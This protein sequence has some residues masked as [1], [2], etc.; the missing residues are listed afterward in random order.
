VRPRCRGARHRTGRADVLRHLPDH[1]VPPGRRRPEGGHRRPARRQALHPR[2]GRRRE[3]QRARGRGAVAHR[4]GTTRHARGGPRHHPGP[5]RR[6]AGDRRRRA[7]PGRPGQALGPAERA[8]RGGRGGLRARIGL[9]LRPAADHLVTTLPDAELVEDWHETR[10]DAGLERGRVFVQIPVSWD[11]SDAE[12]ALDRAHELFRWSGLDWPVNANL[13]D[14]K[15]F[16]AATAAVRREDVAESVP[17][18]PDL[19]A[20]VEVAKTWWDAGFTDIALVQ[21]DGSM[22][23]RFFAEAAEPL[24]E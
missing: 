19:D 3:P 17:C 8:R 13:P 2:P 16:E 12:A 20:V 18:G 9:P 21:I 11:P 15:A 22:Q 24:L 6:R 4:G 7:L 10:A 1:A 14:T 23:D 5:A